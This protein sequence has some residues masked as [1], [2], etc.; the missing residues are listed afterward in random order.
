MLK[1]KISILYKRVTNELNI[2]WRIVCSAKAL[3]NSQNH[4]YI[5]KLWDCIGCRLRDMLMNQ[6]D[7]GT[8]K[9]RSLAAKFGKLLLRMKTITL[10]VGQLATGV[11]VPEDWWLCYVIWNHRLS[12][13]RLLFRPKSIFWTEKGKQWWKERA[14]VFDF[15]PERMINYLW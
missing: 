2:H 9:P 14:Y 8:E 12:I 11:T 3:R 15:A 10:S 4:L 5:W 13:C 6:G 7:E 1:T